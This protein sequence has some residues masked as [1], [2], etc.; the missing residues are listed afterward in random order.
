MKCPYCAQDIDD[1]AIVCSYCQRDLIFFNP[2]AARL[3]ALENRVLEIETALSKNTLIQNHPDAHTQ[4]ARVPFG[5]LCAAIVLGPILCTVGLAYLYVVLHERLLLFGLFMLSPAPFGFF[6][7][8]KWSGGHRIIYFLPGL[9]IGLLNWTVVNTFLDL[10]YQFLSFIL[11]VPPP[12]LMFILMAMIGRFST[13]GEFKKAMVGVN[14]SLTTILTF[15][16]L[17]ISTLLSFLKILKQ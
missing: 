9:I 3:K 2:I 12:S 7:G 8:R 4:T 1:E 14:T 6:L 5:F 15:I 16:G 10:P 17:I 11:F 13:F